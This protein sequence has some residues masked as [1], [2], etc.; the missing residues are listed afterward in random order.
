MGKGSVNVPASVGSGNLCKRAD[1]VQHRTYAILEG[2]GTFGEAPES[3][4]ESLNYPNALLMSFF[5]DFVQ[6]VLSTIEDQEALKKE[7]N[8]RYGTLSSVGVMRD[9]TTGTKT[10]ESLVHFE[11]QTAQGDLGERW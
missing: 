10:L 9:V 5:G 8:G 6:F 1:E 3:V 2:F 4:F 11:T 7:K